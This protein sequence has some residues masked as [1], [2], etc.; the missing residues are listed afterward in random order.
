MRLGIIIFFGLLLSVGTGHTATYTALSCE[1]KTG[2]TDVQ[3][4]VN[5]A[6][7]GDTVIVPAG[8]CSW[9]TALEITKIIRLRGA[10]VGLTN[11]TSGVATGVNS[12][13]IKYDP[14]NATADYLFEVTGFSFTIPGQRNGL[15]IYQSHSTTAELKKTR[16][17][18]NI[19]TNN[20]LGYYVFT[21]Q[22]N[23]DSAVVD[24]NTFNGFQS[25][26]IGGKD[27]DTWENLTAVHGSGKGLYFE[28]NTYNGTISSAFNDGFQGSRWTVRYNHLINDQD[29][30]NVFATDMHGNQPS[31]TG[32][33]SGELY[34]NLITDP[35]NRVTKTL[36]LRGGKAIVFNNYN[37]S[38]RAD[39]YGVVI[40]NEYA[41]S[42]NPVVNPAGQPQYTSDSYFWN[43]WTAGG[44][45]VAIQ[46]NAYS[47]DGPDTWGE[48]FEGQQFWRMTNTG[49]FDG[50]GRATAGGGVGC[51]TLAARPATCTTG[52][53]YWATNQRCDNLDGMVGVSPSTPI[54]GTLYKCTST[55][56]WG[57]P[58]YTPYTYPHLLRRLGN[59]LSGGVVVG[60]TF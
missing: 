52:V 8:S 39:F 4:A 14:V 9:D 1:N 19:F 25:F 11:I 60:G 34:G 12:Y 56:T 29:E 17:H 18:H 57:E 41:D 51:G 13:T 22:A 47:V 46:Q 3:D 20:T 5:S 10:G 48:V 36:D 2:Q 26:Q 55:D 58:Y 23:F 33:M 45:K 6:S 42:V 37:T 32:A 15:V 38:T 21:A 30:S 54:S 44:K 49:T 53:A 40:R 7:D 35:N 50:T 16:I 31:A 59:Q 27:T 28:D 24:N 43:D